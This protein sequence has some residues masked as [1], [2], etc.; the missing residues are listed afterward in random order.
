MPFVSSAGTDNQALRDI[1]EILKEIK[2]QSKY[3]FGITIAVFLI[4]LIQLIFFVY[5]LKLTH[6]NL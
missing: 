5:Q 3:M 2:K 4:A 1:K 6:Q